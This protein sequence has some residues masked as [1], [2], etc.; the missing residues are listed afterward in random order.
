M[1][2]G[3]T[4]VVDILV[5]ISRKMWTWPGHIMCRIDS[6]WSF[7]LMEWLPRKGKRSRGRQRVRWSGKITKFAR[8]KWNEPYKVVSEMEIIGR[9]LHPAMNKKIGL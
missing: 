3:Q 4:G 6:R 2:R 8:I 9:G 1:V 7:R 5:D